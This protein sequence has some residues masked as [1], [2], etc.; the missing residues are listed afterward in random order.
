[1]GYNAPR[2]GVMDLPRIELNFGS[3]NVF[4]KLSRTRITTMLDH[5]VFHMYTTTK[6]KVGDL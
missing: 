2:G 5:M 1:M 3:T 4:Y 6:T